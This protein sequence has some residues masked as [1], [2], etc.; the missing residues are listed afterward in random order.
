MQTLHATH[1]HTPSLL[2]V[3]AHTRTHTHTQLHHTRTH[4]HTRAHTHTH[5]RSYITVDALA[6]RALFYV[7]VESE[8]SPADDPLVLWLNGWEWLL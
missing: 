2:G 1:T 6:G 5:T 3:H 8:R 7:Y 4:S